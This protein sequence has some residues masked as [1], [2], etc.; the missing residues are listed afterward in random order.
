MEH[1]QTSFIDGESQGGGFQSSELSF[2]QILLTHLSRIT[3]IASQEFHGGYWDKKL[4][5]GSTMIDVY[6]PDPKKEYIN[7]V[8]C[9]ADLLLP[10][11]DDVMLK[12]EEDNDNK[13]KDKWSIMKEAKGTN[14][15]WSYAKQSLKRELFRD[16]NLFMKRKNYLELGEMED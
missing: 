10:Y 16:L 14:D 9:L 3:K 6:V 7:A 5:G 11:F 4:V 1:S 2:R 13:I 15:E 12:A 8:N